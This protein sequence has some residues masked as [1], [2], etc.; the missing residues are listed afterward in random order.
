MKKNDLDSAIAEA[1]TAVSHEGESIFNQA[2]DH[3]LRG[4]LYFMSAKYD[5][6]AAD[7]ETVVKRRADHTDAIVWLYLAR[8]RARDP[9]AS[10]ALASESKALN[11]GRPDPIWDGFIGVSRWLYP[12]VPLFLGTSTPEATLASAA[13]AEQRCIL[14][15]FVGEWSLLHDDAIA[16]RQRFDAAVATECSRDAVEYFAARTELARLAK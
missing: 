14:Q 5:A 4:R 10:A 16:A 13:N 11:D 12:L 7:F 1:T 9:N 15:F 2:P 3:M 6:A 8:A